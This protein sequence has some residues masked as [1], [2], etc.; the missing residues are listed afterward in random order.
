MT[1]KT[2]DLI[3]ILRRQIETLDSLQV[4]YTKTMIKDLEDWPETPE[5]EDLEDLRD[6]L[7]YWRDSLS[8]VSRQIE[9]SKSQIFRTAKSA[10]YIV[11]L[12]DSDHGLGL[13]EIFSLETRVSRGLRV[14]SLTLETVSVLI[15]TVRP[16]PETEDPETPSQT[17]QTVR[18]SPDRSER[19]SRT[20]YNGRPG[21]F[22]SETGEIVSETGDLLYSP[23]QDWR[24]DPADF[25]IW[26]QTRKTD[27]E[28]VSEKTDYPSETDQ[29]SD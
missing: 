24:P 27:P 8:K 15:E 9:I 10:G 16:S 20:V 5:I 6:N 14:F 13:S 12:G 1:P 22:D 11:R 4:C 2:Q 17:R 26:R 21:V 18:P 25:E 28:T 3:I 19:Y 23:G 7:S 29:S